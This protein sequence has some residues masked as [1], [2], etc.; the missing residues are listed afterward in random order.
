MGKNHIK[1]WTFDGTTQ[2][3]IRVNEVTETSAKITVSSDPIEVTLNIG[4]SKEV[5]INNDGTND[6]KVTL[7]SITSGKASFTL[8]KLA[9]AAIVEQEE[10]EEAESSECGNDQ[11]EAGENYINC[12][13]DC[14]APTPDE[15]PKASLTWLWILIGIIIVAI[16]GY[17]TSRKKQKK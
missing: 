1:T 11:C 3:T 16:V 9:G 5:D 8:T 14:E 2:H 4:E 10:Q 13:S 17:T 7:D 12:P 6:I 15:E